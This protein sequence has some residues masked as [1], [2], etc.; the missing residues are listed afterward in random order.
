MTEI[1]FSKIF[2]Y[3]KKD[4]KGNHIIPFFDALDERYGKAPHTLIAES[5]LISIKAHIKHIA[6]HGG[7]YN[8]PPVSAHYNGQN[9]GIIKISEGEELIRI[10]FYAKVG[11]EMVVL[12][13]KEKPS[14]YD[15]G[16]K[17]KVEKE[18]QKWLDEAEE[19]LKEY[20]E[21]RERVPFLSYF[22]HIS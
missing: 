17:K 19:Y 15:K 14:L 7:R 1:P 3:C 16:K 9:V 13:I 22:S 4:H 12:S 8:C 20:K 18:M 5:H 10:A 2:V 11:D 6:L 21:N